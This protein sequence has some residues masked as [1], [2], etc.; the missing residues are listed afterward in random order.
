MLA[1]SFRRIIA[2]Q[3]SAFKVCRKKN[4]AEVGMTFELNGEEIEDFAL[5]PVGA[6]P[7]G[8][9]RVNDGLLAANAGAQADAGAAGDGKKLVV[10]FEARLDGVAVD[11]GNVAQEIELQ[12]RILLADLGGAAQKILGN[13]EGGLAA[14]LH[15]LRDSI[16]VPTAKLFDYK[17]SVCVCGLR[18]FSEILD[19]GWRYF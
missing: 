4:A 3:R 8:E 9:E 12:S 6:A 18:H 7:E 15:D 13:D 19:Q 17:I 14:K 1:W 2:A 5:E 11:A 16:R 10:E